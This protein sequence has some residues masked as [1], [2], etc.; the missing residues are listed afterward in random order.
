MQK[1]EILV[2]YGGDISAMAKSLASEANLAGLIGDRGKWVGLKPNLVVARPASEGATTHVEIAAG[3]IAYLKENG[4]DNLAI[5]EGAWVGASTSDAF[6]ACGYVALAKE[7]G[8]ALIDTQ[9]DKTRSCDCKGLAIEI[10]GSALAIDFMINLP[11]MKGHCQT[12]VTCALKNN[13]GVIP[14][15]E[16]RRFHSLGLTKP[17]AH[18]NTVARSD[19]ILVDGICGDL[20][21]EEGGNPVYSSR[22]FAA[23]D[24]VLCDAWAAAQMGYVAADIPYIGLAEKLGVGSADLRAA[25]VRELN[26]CQSAG[27][28]ASAPSGKVRALSPYITEDSS[29][30]A[31]YASL[32]FALSR[33]GLNELNR[34]R[35]KVCVGQGFRGKKGGLGVGQCCSAF[36][37]Y[38]PGCP[39][40]GADILAFLRGVRG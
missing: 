36:S 39:P 20:D 2:I 19:F 16:K 18:L 3:L 15:R 9:K 21:F 11:V 31:C 23:R 28:A 7:T 17:I 5:L 10:C 34:L 22:M 37:A 27:G 25:K 29:C 14:D 38:C 30:S 26:T 32:V 4:F 12:L 40:S 6:N 13:K 33:M 35:E 8:V 1:N 24:P